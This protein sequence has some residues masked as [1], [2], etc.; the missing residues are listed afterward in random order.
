MN[1]TKYLKQHFPNAYAVP[2][3]STDVT[4]F[5][6]HLLYLSKDDKYSFVEGISKSNA[7]TSGGL[8][9]ERLL[10]EGKTLEEIANRQKG[11]FLD[12]PPEEPQINIFHLN[13]KKQWFD[14]IRS[15]EKKEE[16]REIKPYWDDR[17]KPGHF[18]VKGEW[19]TY[20]A[21][22][23]CFSNGYGL[24]RPQVYMEVKGIQ[25]K[26]GRED[27]GAEKGKAY[28]AIALGEVLL[29]SVSKKGY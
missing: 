29:D 14:M 6:P 5:K 17:L 26:E 28:Y 24:D 22:I 3:K 13:L 12:E 4:H 18:K 11:I 19:V 10:S 15:G 9:L 2:D 23:I 21:C 1:Y 25:I 20:K 8:R 16:Y 27:W 7:F